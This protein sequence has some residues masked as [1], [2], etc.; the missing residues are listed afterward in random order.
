MILRYN[1]AAGCRTVGG[2]NTC[3]GDIQD[4]AGKSASLLTKTQRNRIRDD[5]DDLGEE[6]KRRDQQRIR[7]RVKSGLLD[8]QLLADYPDRQLVMAFDDASEEELRAALTD[9]TLVVERLR[10]LHGIDRTELINETRTRA[11]ALSDTTTGTESLAQTELRTP[12]EI[13]RQ[14]EAEVEDRLGTGRWDKHANRLAKLGA[15]AFIPLVLIGILDWYISGNFLQEVGGIFGFLMVILAVSLVGWLL[16]VA[17]QALK[18][19]I[20]PAFLKLVRN[21]KA[22]VQGAFTDLIKSPKKTVREAW[23]EL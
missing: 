18:H 14:T 17:A 10:E 4:M 2:Y 20:L 12:A 11:E 22:A 13:R 21:P 8:F 23:D 5:F 15:C 7:E 19:D 16:I 6:K 1:A 9:T 3:T